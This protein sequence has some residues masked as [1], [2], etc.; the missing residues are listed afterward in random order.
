MLQE[1]FPSILVLKHWL[2]DKPPAVRSC[3]AGG[4]RYRPLRCSARLDS[5]FLS[6]LL[7]LSYRKLPHGSKLIDSAELMAR[8]LHFNDGPA[9]TPKITQHMR[10]ASATPHSIHTLSHGLD[11]SLRENSNDVKRNGGRGPRRTR[12]LQTKPAAPIALRL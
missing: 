9:D 4:N 11:P 1:K 8:K 7:T 6:T 3:C 12:L 2:R 10:R 5:P